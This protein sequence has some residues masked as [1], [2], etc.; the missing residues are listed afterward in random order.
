MLA[1]LLHDCGKGLGEGSDTLK[2]GARLA[3]DVCRRLG[4]GEQAAT[5]N[6]VFLI[7]HH[8]LMAQTSRLRDLHFGRDHP[9]LC[10]RRP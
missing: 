9:R 3:L 6:V 1:A 4:W 2:I 5:A 10:A 7:E 8:L